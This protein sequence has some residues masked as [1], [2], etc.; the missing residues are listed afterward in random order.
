MSGNL[1]HRKIAFLYHKNID[2]GKLQNMHFTLVHSSDQHF[3]VYIF[4]FLFLVKIARERCLATF[5]TEK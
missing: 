5:F 2:L 4:Y 3:D 1:L